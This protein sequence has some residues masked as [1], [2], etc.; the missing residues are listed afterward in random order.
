[1][2]R[3]P[4]RLGC[5]CLKVPTAPPSQTCPITNVIDLAALL[6]RK[7]SIED[8]LVAVNQLRKNDD[9]VVSHILIS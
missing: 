4:I 2:D 7:N 6:W 1:M 5:Q 8:G 3:H 9:V